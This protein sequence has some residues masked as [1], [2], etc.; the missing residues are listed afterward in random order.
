VVLTQ[1]AWSPVANAKR[2]RQDQARTAAKV[3]KQRTRFGIIGA[4]ALVLIVGLLVL[5]GRGG[6]SNESV[7]GKPEAPTGEGAR[8]T[9]IVREEIRAG[10]GDPVA[11]GDTVRIKYV[12]KSWDGKN[13]YEGGWSGATPLQISGVAAK[14]QPAIWAQLVGVKA[15]GRVKLS[16]PKADA[17][18]IGA[19]D[20]VT[21]LVD[22]MSR[23]AGAG[24][25]PT[26]V[27][28]AP[29]TDAA[30]TTKAAPTTEAAPTTVG[31]N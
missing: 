26:S 17:S 27:P 18:T 28:A 20:A 8:P 2:Q 3:K 9:K 22:V 6:D 19:E 4:A 14:G 24:T 23:E 1:L 13:S 25:S 5:T 21:L 16:V 15:T 29:P 11:V 30:G 10:V 7:A 12:G 31:A